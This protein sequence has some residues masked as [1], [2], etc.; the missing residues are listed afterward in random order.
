MNE[1][2]E[3][4]NIHEYLIGHTLVTPSFW[5]H[6]TAAQEIQMKL[7]TVQQAIDKLQIWQVPCPCVSLIRESLCHWPEAPSTC[8]P[9]CSHLSLPVTISAEGRREK[10]RTYERSIPQ[11][12]GNVVLSPHLYAILYVLTILVSL[13]FLPVSVLNMIRERSFVC[14]PLCSVTSEF[15]FLVLYLEATIALR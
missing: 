13:L 3:T 11:D 15:T 5:P 2:Y 7:K 14:E 8:G 10:G 6:I 1:A 12:S 4:L 9:S